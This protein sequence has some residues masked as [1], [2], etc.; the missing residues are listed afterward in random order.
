MCDLNRSTKQIFSFRALLGDGGAP[1]STNI[2]HTPKTK[3]QK[4][5]QPMEAI[6][7][8][9]EDFFIRNAKRK[10]RINTEKLFDL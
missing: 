6:S 1:I 4:C 8:F 5:K 9:L 7:I 3:S 10:L 2:T